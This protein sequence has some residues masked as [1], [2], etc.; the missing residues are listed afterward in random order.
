M[1]LCM[2]CRF[3]AACIQSPCDQNAAAPLGRNERK[4]IGHWLFCW[5]RSLLPG[6]ESHTLPPSV[7]NSCQQLKCSCFHSQTQEMA[8]EYRLQ[9]F[10]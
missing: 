10:A 4:L 5:H 6:Y 8:P 9:Q 3:Q 1:V 2:I 7:L